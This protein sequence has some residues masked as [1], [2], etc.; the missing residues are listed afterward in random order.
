MEDTIIKLPESELQIM[1]TIWDLYYDG[2]KNITAGLIMKRYPE[3]TRLKLTTILTLITRL[4]IK[5]YVSVNKDGRSNCYTPLISREEYRKFALEDFIDKVY[6]GDRS[7]LLS[8][9]K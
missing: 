7:A 2:E 4:Q 6:L 3:L 8:M 1:Q 9:L 5:G